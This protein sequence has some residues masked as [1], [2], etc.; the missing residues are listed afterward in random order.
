[1]A[2]YDS[3]QRTR[4]DVSAGFGAG[5]GPRSGPG[6]R[7]SDHDASYGGITYRWGSGGFYGGPGPQARRGTSHEK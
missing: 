7:R 3:R 4:Y 2:R 6:R 1:M 5:G